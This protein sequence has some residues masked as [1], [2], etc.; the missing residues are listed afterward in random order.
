[1]RIRN[2]IRRFLQMCLTLATMHQACATSHSGITA[3]MSGPN[4]YQTCALLADKRI[5]CWG[6]GLDTAAPQ[7][8]AGQDVTAVALGDNFGCAIVGN[9]NVYCWGGTLT[10]LGTSNSSG[11]MG[12][13]TTTPRFT[14]APA[15]TT[16]GRNFG[17]ATS[18][19]AGS[20]YACAV[21]TDSSLWCW[22]GSD[23][24]QIGNF[25][26]G[27]GNDVLRPIQVIVQDSST[28]PPNPPL[29]HVKSVTA[30]YWTTCAL[31]TDNHAACW[32]YGWD[33]ELGTGE[34]HLDSVD[35]PLTVVVPNDKGDYVNLIFGGGQLAAGQ[36]HTC[37][38]IADSP[39]DSV[40]CWG[41]NGHAQLGDGTTAARNI[42]V[43]STDEAGKIT[44]AFAVSAGYA[45][46]CAILADSTVRCWGSDHESELGQAAGGSNSA[47]GIKIVNADNSPLNGITQL[48]TGA[49]HACGLSMNGN[50]YCWGDN[51]YGQ[52]GITS[53]NQNTVPTA[54]PIDATLFFDNFGE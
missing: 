49:Y 30:G 35:S 51:S 46:T 15:L 29:L 16:D 9:G 8:I 24:G 3:I 38:L 20:D 36:Y 18:I 39:L 37:G 19:A 7:D 21:L 10:T 2:G 48:A 34:F 33:G 12:D 52:L 5:D 45:F 53:P 11:Q 4:A 43:A 50:V 31:F 40:A 42:A 47:T 13:G 54:V 28:T 44:N 32:G 22:G 27:V 14:A 6:N 41:T 25:N 26:I 1:M 17:A 23:H